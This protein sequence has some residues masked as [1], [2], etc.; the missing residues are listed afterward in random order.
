MKAHQLSGCTV[1]EYRQLEIENDRKYEYHNGEIFALAGGSI[2]HGLLCGNIYA[3]IRSALKQKKSP[4]KPVNSEIK[5]NVRFGKTNSFLYPDT[6]V[7]FGDFESAEQ[8]ENAVMNPVLIVEV[9]AK[10]T[11]EYDRG[12][13][14]YLYRQIEHLQEYV[15]IEQDKYIVDVY[16]KNPQSDLWRIS[17]VEGIESAVTLQSIGITIPMRELYF[18]IELPK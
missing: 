2:S 18:D 4:C 12:D 5:L 15:L 16:S 9:L 10:S 6:M 17:R 13:K 14:F 3:E 1:E 7:I 11:A 8:D